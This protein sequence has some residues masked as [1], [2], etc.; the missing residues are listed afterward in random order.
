MGADLFLHSAFDPYYGEWQRRFDEAVRDRDALDEKDPKQVEAQERVQQCFGKMYETGYFR[1]SYNSSNVL[2]KFGL[3]WW[4]DVIP[5]LDD[6]HHL[7]VENARKLLTL[8]DTHEPVFVENLST[9]P[10]DVY[11]DFQE[12]ADELRSFL[13]HAISLNEP[14]DCSL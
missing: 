7:S 6:D 14:I 5:L 2:W 13:E 4:D 8:L 12:R 1:D 9:V 11:R 3:S 10:L